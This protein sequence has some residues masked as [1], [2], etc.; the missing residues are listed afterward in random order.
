M[1]NIKEK[2]KDWLLTDEI[3]NPYS[4]TLKMFASCEITA[5]KHL[6]FF[7][8]RYERAIERRNRRYLF[9]P[10]FE[11]D[12]GN[13]HYHIIA[14]RPEDLSHDIYIKR[15]NDSINKTKQIRSDYND[16]KKAYSIEG[17]FEYSIK[18][19]TNDELLELKA[20]L[21]ILNL[22]R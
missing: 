18:K 10:T 22:R 5:S 11:P 1:Q 3:Q 7:R 4:I 15:I 14:N 6:R 13:P 21:D 20:E 12:I 16:I 2:L 9:I 8:N 19:I 17:A